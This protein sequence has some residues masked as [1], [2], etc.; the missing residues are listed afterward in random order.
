MIRLTRL[1]GVLLSAVIG[2]PA[3]AAYTCT[4]ANSAPFY[5]DNGLTTTI[6]CPTACPDGTTYL[7][8]TAHLLQEG[9]CVNGDVNLLGPTEVGSVISTIGTCPAAPAACGT[10]PSGTLWYADNGTT[11]T[12]ACGTAC[13]DGS[14]LQCVYNLQS[15][16]SCTNGVTATTGLTQN[17]E[18]VST[19]GSCPVTEAACGEHPSGTLWYADNGSSTTAACGTACADGSVLQCNYAVQSQYSCSNG[20]TTA[21]G[22]IQTGA[23][24][25]QNGSCPVAPAACGNYA[26]GSTWFADNGSTVTAACADACSDGSILQ[27]VYD[28]QSQYL[29]TNGVT[30][31]T[32]VAQ[33]GSLVSTVGTCPVVTTPVTPPP[34]ASCGNNASGTNWWQN[35]GTT[36][37]T[38]CGACTDGTP[39]QCVVDVQAQYTCTNG[40]TSA[41]G[42]LQNG[43]V[44]SYVNECLPPAPASCGSQASGSTWWLNSGTQNAACQTCWDG[45]TITC[46]YNTQNQESCLNGV[47]T[48][49]GATARGSLISQSGTCPVQ[50]AS[51][52][53]TAS[54]QTVWRDAGQTAPYACG[55][56]IDGSA[57]LCVSV[58]ESQMLCTNGK[59]SPTGK[60][61]PGAF[62]GYSNT[63]PTV[64]SAKQSFQVPKTLGKADVLF[65]IDTTPTMFVTVQTLAHRFGAL[66]S[67]WRGID[68]QVALSNA[69]AVPTPF[70]AHP[71]AGHLMALNTYPL[72]T[73]S[74]QRILSP[75]DPY[76]DYIFGLNMGF[77]GYSWPGNKFC[78]HQPYCQYGPSE[79]LR[80]ILETMQKRNE[81]VNQGFFR[82]GATFVPVII[83]AHD[84][85]NLGGPSVTKAADVE[86]YFK[87]ALPHMKA[88][89]AYSFVIQPGDADCLKE[90]SSI[91]NQGAGGVYGVSL[92]KFSKETNG[93]TFSICERNYG[94]SLAS[95]SQAV[96]QQVSSIQLAEVP[97][98]QSLKITFTPKIPGIRWVV[99]GRDVLFSEPLPA[100][101]RVDVT[102]RYSPK[103]LAKSRP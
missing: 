17:G 69:E 34:P 60:T 16:Y 37:V 99:Q 48:P 89:K 24:E 20:V 94:K 73:P 88:M 68:W 2:G 57:H 98:G 23:V 14:V 29:C 81:S 61:K 85:K 49:T 76:A 74:P 47:T 71:S 90:F 65:V 35:N 97:Y 44:V 5:L 38:T 103:H 86:A 50:P 62:I 100:G 87:R 30:T 56:C 45:S 77:A 67:G 15:Q 33:N 21:T 40:T 25:S 66:V 27:C 9:E 7:Q 19:V 82:D 28:S 36:V 84:E 55:T 11:T 52:D 58:Q 42:Q 39:H 78:D 83:S 63:C 72:V 1:A 54:G 101:T 31:T 12:A 91:F 93:K 80:E 10:N 51:C 59:L 46:T 8:C 26:S 22:L 75:R 13:A 41:T 3:L 79:P 96:R 102:Y 70:G 92:A 53:G 95:L 43:D 6:T 18:L 32:G 4:V 64:L